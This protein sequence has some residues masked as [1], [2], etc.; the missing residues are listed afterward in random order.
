MNFSAF[1]RLFGKIY[2]VSPCDARQIARKKVSKTKVYLFRKRCAVS[3]CFSMRLQSSFTSRSAT[4]P[5]GISATEQPS[6]KARTNA[7]RYPIGG[8]TT[9]PKPANSSTNCRPSRV[10]ASTRLGTRI[11]GGCPCRR[12][13][14]GLTI[15]S[16]R[17][18]AS[19]SIPEGVH[20]TTTKLHAAI[21]ALRASSL[22]AVSRTTYS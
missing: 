4:C 10:R 9:S 13:R 11:R 18:V 17:A 2:G 3:R 12:A 15:S 19:R 1:S 22:G 14:I 21:V 20:G 6:E 7:V 5:S 16:V 8:L